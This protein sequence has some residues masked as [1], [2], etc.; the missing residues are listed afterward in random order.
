MGKRRKVLFVTY[1]GGHAR[2][3]IPV[4]RRL[5]Q[6]DDIAVEVLACTSAGPIFRSAGL[7]HW[8]YKDFLRDDD[9]EARAWGIKLAATHHNPQCGI[10]HEESIAYLGLCY[11]ELIKRNGAEMAGRLFK[12]R[13]AQAFLPLNALQRVIA[14]AQPD[15]VVTTNSARSE[16]AA[17]EVARRH[18][19]PT[20]S[21]VDLF[22]L[23]H[24]YKLSAD[25]IATLS[26]ITVQNLRADNV[27]GGRHGFHVTGN[28]AFDE[29][30]KYRGAADRAWR[31]KQFGDALASRKLLLW[32]D[33]PAYW[34]DETSALHVRTSEEITR[35]L[36]DLLAAARQSQAG[37]LVRP[38]PSQR[39]D[40][41]R[42]WMTGRRPE[43]AML[44]DDLPLYPLLNAV[45]AVATY[46]STVGIEAALVLKPV[47]Q[48]QYHQGRNDL[49]LGELGLAS[50]VRSPTD[51]KGAVE[52]ALTTPRS[53]HELARQV[54]RVVP[55]D[56][57]TDRVVDLIEGICR[58]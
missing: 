3:V 34:N 18:G 49:P 37:L 27:P 53:D 21:L 4:I 39:L 26:P 7:S 28:P 25:H 30:F 35:D 9:W 23:F 12:E 8:N 50:L 11:W 44:V 56:R 14:R 36:D 16:Q 15:L 32:I 5:Q 20:L 48:L 22:G 17:V 45:D 29:V 1:G 19:I 57:A 55:V 38:H 31:A 51:M 2:M 33:V 54:H 41:Y 46:N 52:Q 13:G 40:T 43:H 6:H 42:E 24:F 58:S 47:I 10:E